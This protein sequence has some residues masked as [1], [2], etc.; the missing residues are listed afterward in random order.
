MHS[1]FTL[2]AGVQTLSG[3][4]Y[5]PTYMSCYGTAHNDQC[6]I[7]MESIVRWVLVYNTLSACKEHCSCN[8]SVLSILP[9]L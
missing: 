6:L 1:H 7:E 4:V 9:V 2:A 8:L 3:T 5:L